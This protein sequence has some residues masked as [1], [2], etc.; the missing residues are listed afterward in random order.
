MSMPKNHSKPFPWK[1]GHCRKRAVDLSS[2]PYSVELEHDGRSYSVSIP[3]LEAPRCKECGEVVLDDAAN[4]RI[5]DAFRRQLGLLTPKQIRSNREAL[6]MTQKQLA[7]RLGIA[8]ATLSRWE[9]GGQIQQRALD[10]LLRLFFELAEVRTALVDDADV[11]ELGTS[12]QYAPDTVSPSL[13]PEVSDAI[14]IAFTDAWGSL[15]TALRHRLHGSFLRTW[16]E[17]EPDITASLLPFFYWSVNADRRSLRS[18]RTC[19]ERRMPS[20][21]SAF[22]ACSGESRWFVVPIKSERDDDTERATRISRLAAA[23]DELPEE[24]EAA[25]IDEFH[26]LVLLILSGPKRGKHT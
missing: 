3:D 6:L 17:R 2:E 8:E 7:S 11:C 26:R 22:A 24:T 21:E 1:C 19:F 25:A 12:V 13:G 18:W 9:N 15:Q 23:L 10:R 5:S 14:R 20:P 16:E 4:Q